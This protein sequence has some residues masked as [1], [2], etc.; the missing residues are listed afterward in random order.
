MHVA[1]HISMRKNIVGEG[2]SSRKASLFIIRA[3]ACANFAKEKML[4][5]S[6]FSLPAKA[7]PLAVCPGQEFRVVWNIPLRTTRI[8]S[9]ETLVQ[10]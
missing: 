9:C 1:R 2:G 4:S 8:P 6:R 7:W 5:H 10:E 3:V